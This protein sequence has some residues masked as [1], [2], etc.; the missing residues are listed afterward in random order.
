M[1]KIRARE[2]IP[3]EL[4]F[5]D[6][7]AAPPRH[8]DDDRYDGTAGETQ[9]YDEGGGA[10]DGTVD[11]TATADDLAPE[12]LLDENGGGAPLAGRDAEDVSLTVVD[13]DRIGGG[14]GLDEAELAI[15]EGGGPRSGDD[16][17]DEDDEE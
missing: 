1:A 13:E 4:N 3:A 17:E 2:E 9:R 6:D 15:A 7:R 16:S 8:P 12:T 10:P 14:K 11:N 5:D